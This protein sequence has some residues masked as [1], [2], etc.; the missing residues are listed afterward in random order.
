MRISICVLLG[1]AFATSAAAS[2]DFSAVGARTQQVM[3][4][5]NVTDGGIVIGTPRGILYKQ[6]FGTYDDS[7]VIALASA[8]KMLSGVRIMQ[9]VDR[10]A[11][12]LDT[13]VSTYLSEFSGT[14]GTMTMREMFSH[15]S[16]YGDDE[17]SAILSANV[18]LA[19]AVA[20]IACCMDQPY[21]PPGAY[22]AYGGISM[23]VGGEVAQ[24]QGNEDWQAGWIAHVGSPLGITT[25]D[26][27]GLGTT[28]NYR[29]AGGGETSLPDYARLLAMLAGNGVGNGHRILSPNAVATMNHIQTA[30]ATLAYSPPAADGSTAYG[31]GAWIETALFTDADTPVMS[32]IGKFGFTPWVDF[33]Y[34]YFGAL[35]IEQRTESAPETVG[36]KTHDALIDISGIVRAQLASSCPLVET[37]DE[38]FRDGADGLP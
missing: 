20:Y 26:W 29:I 9:L 19:N 32:S 23:Q 24:V 28:Q 12:D 7:S 35:M 1:T 6:Y 16:G 30:G 31:I 5:A 27:Q 36:A 25:I 2:C 15:T 11:I 14:K 8:T 13:P 18:T 37:Y 38:I 22:F 4:A 3:Q 33:G 34:G 21:P 10:G 17:D